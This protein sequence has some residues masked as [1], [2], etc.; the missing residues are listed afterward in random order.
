MSEASSTPADL[1]L[2]RYVM[3]S[4]CIAVAALLVVGI[5]LLDL[6]NHRLN[7]ALSLGVIAVQA[8]LVLWFMMHLFSEKRLIYAVLGFTGF[9]LV[10]LML[11]TIWSLGEVPEKSKHPLP[12]AA[13]TAK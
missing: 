10:F 8:A 1:H 2:R 9:F 7:I 12:H 11:L 4:V 3:V 6:G 5:N 13:E